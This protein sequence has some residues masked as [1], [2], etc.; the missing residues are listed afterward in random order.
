MKLANIFVTLDGMRRLQCCSIGDMDSAKM[1]IAG[2]KA[3]TVHFF[4]SFILNSSL[5]D[6]SF[7]SF[8]FFFFFLFFF[9]FF[10][11]LT[12]L[13]SIYPFSFRSL[14]HLGIWPLK[15]FRDLGNTLTQLMVFILI[16]FILFYFILFLLL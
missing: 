14:V 6:C 13:R 1:L 10:F 7:S 2:A 3:V 9:F 16:Y 4:P 11:F 8:F 12:I 5:N 15:F